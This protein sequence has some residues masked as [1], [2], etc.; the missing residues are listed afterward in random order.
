[1]FESNQL[2]EENERQAGVV[3]NGKLSVDVIDACV[4]GELSSE[5]KPVMIKTKLKFR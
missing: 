3:T 5:E 2:L 1:M 4:N